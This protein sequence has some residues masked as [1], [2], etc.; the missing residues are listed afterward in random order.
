MPSS[1]LTN[2]LNLD[3]IDD[4][5]KLTQDRLNFYTVKL[6]QEEDLS[7]FERAALH[8]QIKRDTTHIKKW[9]FRMRQAINK[10]S[11]PLDE[12]ETR[13]RELESLERRHLRLLKA[14]PNTLIDYEEQKSRHFTQGITFYKL[15]WVLF[16]G[17]FTG[18]VVET[19]WCFIKEGRIESRAGLV[20]GP[21]NLV[22]GL[23]ALVLTLALY[24]Y[25]N[26]SKLYSF[27]GGAIAGSAVEYLCSWLQET[28]FGSTSWDYSTKPFN[29]NGRICLEYAVFW[30]ILGV[31]WIKSIYPRMAQIIM[32]IPNK[33]GK[34]LTWI[35]F[36]FIV[37]D[38]A[39][40][41]VAVYRWSERSADIPASNIIE[42]VLDDR[43]GDTRMEGIYPTLKFGNIGD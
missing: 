17:C 24:R 16:L 8:A 40:S 42:K 32:K 22:Y 26:R 9:R 25:R 27:I 21:F 36:A 1:D 28:V 5:E 2:L 12:V 14:P 41:G 31:L 34:A 13:L 37:L 23:G 4:F 6:S 33:R 43:F 30:G 18:V 3:D 39:V 11:E 38:A 7:P 35:L 10:L 29:L 20:W 15:F 19:L